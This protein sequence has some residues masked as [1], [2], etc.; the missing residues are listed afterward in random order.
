M[1]S[2]STPSR[3]VLGL[4][5]L[6]QAWQIP[7][8]AGYS[9]LDCPYRIHHQGGNT[10]GTICQQPGARV[11]SSRGKWCLLLKRSETWGSLTATICTWW[12]KVT[13]WFPENTPGISPRC[14]L[15]KVRP[16]SI[17]LGCI[18][19]YWVRSLGDSTWVVFDGHCF[20]LFLLVQA[21]S[22]TTAALTHSETQGDYWLLKRS[23]PLGDNFPNG[24]TFWQ[25]RS[26]L[27]GKAL[28]QVNRKYSF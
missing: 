27:L 2:L 12:T 1:A 19:K 6:H 11:Y 8:Q 15:K 23:F 14:R 20:I 10:C 3:G 7:G 21:A 26:P 16:L 22:P 5:T 28:G 24:T 25:R 17:Y 9:R 13:G 4:H 18:L